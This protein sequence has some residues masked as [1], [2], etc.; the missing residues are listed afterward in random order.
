MFINTGWQ[1]DRTLQVLRTS[2][3]GMKSRHNIVC[4]CCPAC[5]LRTQSDTVKVFSV[6]K[7]V[8]TAVTWR[9]KWRRFQARA[10]EI[11]R[12]WRDFRQWISSCR[13][14]SYTLQ[15]R[16]VVKESEKTC[17]LRW[18]ERQLILN[19]TFSVNRFFKIQWKRIN[20]FPEILKLHSPIKEPQNITQSCTS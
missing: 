6:Y 3:L 13:C 9:T 15:G 5:K 8:S 4:C 17:G 11:K 18:Q 12:M 2:V 19:T 10:K 16:I 7:S 20:L 14:T 1:R